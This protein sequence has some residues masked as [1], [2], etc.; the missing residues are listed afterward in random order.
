MINLLVL[1]LS[2]SVPCR[3]LG[4]ELEDL[5]F[6]VRTITKKMYHCYSFLHI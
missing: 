5:I 4:F 6:F 3:R 1:E 2:T